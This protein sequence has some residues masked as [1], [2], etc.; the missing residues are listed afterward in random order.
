V[1][2]ILSRMIEMK[3][4]DAAGEDLFGFRRGKETR[5]AV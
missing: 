1:K 3:I 5:D 4:E 2:N